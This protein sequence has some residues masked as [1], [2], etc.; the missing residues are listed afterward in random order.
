MKTLVLL[1]AALLI[2]HLCSARIGE[3]LDECQLRYGVMLRVESKFRPDYP[4]YVFKKGDIE[5]RVRLYNGLS[6]Q[7]IFGAANRELTFNERREI[8]RANEEVKG[9]ETVS[10]HKYFSE[11]HNDILAITT[12]EFHKVFGE[13]GQTGF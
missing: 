12:K 2:P 9:I 13:A 5:I 3:T 1:C 6:A 7:E 8:E 10:A 4:Q 11:L